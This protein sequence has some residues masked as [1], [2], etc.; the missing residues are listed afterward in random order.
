MVVQRHIVGNAATWSYCN[1]IIG[2]YPTLAAA[3]RHGLRECGHDDFNIAE[4]DGQRMLRWTWMGE[5]LGDTPDDLAWIA[6][7]LGLVTS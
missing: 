7:S 6:E 2:T 3:K 1:H 5:D 4:V